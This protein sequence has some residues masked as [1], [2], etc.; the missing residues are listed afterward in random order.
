MRCNTTRMNSWHSWS[1]NGRWLV[2]TSKQNTPFTQMF[3]THVDEHGDDTP[4]ILVPNST[5]ANRAVNLPEFVPIPPAGL[6]E[7]T[8]PAADYRRHLERARALEAAGQREE[9]RA[10]LARSLALK[11]DYWE[12]HLTLGDLVARDGDPAAAIAH[13]QRALELNPR[14]LTTHLNLG[15]AL[16]RLERYDEALEH[17][18]VALALDPENASN[19]VRVARVL[20]LAGDTE[21]AERYF[22]RAAQLDPK[23]AS[24]QYEWGLFLE[25]RGQL[26]Q[27]IER[28][29]SAAELDLGH[30]WARYQWGRALERLGRIAEALEP[31]RAATEIGPDYAPAHDALALLLASYGDPRLRDGGEAVRLAWIACERTGQAEPRYLDTLAAAYAEVGRFDEARRTAERAVGLARGSGD[32]GLT[33]ELESHLALFERG[34]PLRIVFEG[35][36]WRTNAPR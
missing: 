36:R 23:L 32:A 2:F 25:G 11:P 5:A 24:A 8:T 22:A 6:V 34:L 17:L 3:L 19:T 12:T 14:F 20:G 28:F 13:Y 33:R 16:S 27:A 35:G 15:I 1:P 30:Y 10:E 26:E 21:R 31:L 18:A 29:R 9:A 7:I 4:A